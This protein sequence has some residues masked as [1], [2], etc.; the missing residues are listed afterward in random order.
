MAHLICYI[1]GIA[2]YWN[3]NSYE[4]P[5]RKISLTLKEKYNYK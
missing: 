4:N 3:N 2:K 5:K 1:M